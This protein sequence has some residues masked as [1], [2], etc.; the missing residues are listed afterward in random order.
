MSVID[1]I[2]QYMNCR[3]TKIYTKYEVSAIRGCI[4]L[5]YNNRFSRPSWLNVKTK[6]GKE[7]LNQRIA[8]LVNEKYGLSIKGKDVWLYKKCFADEYS[9]RTGK[10]IWGFKH[11]RENLGYNPETGRE[12]I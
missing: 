6:K 11:V 10:C 2:T 8:N 9:D 7:Y 12:V 3:S 4:K 5:E 1:N